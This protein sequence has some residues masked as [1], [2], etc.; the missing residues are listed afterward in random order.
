MNLDNRGNWTLIGL[1]V[2]VAIVVVGV[3]FMARGSLPTV[4]SDGEL[5]DTASKKQT[6]VGKSIDTGKSAVCQN[7]LSQLR[8]GIEN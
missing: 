2:V 6:V 1:L 8:K 7:Q 3:Y 4:K 5:L